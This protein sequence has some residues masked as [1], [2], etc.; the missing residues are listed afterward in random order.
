MSRRHKKG[1]ADER[2][3]SIP[4]RTWEALRLRGVAPA[5]NAAALYV[6]LWSGP[7]SARI[8]GV[9]PSGRAALSEA[10]GWTLD[11]F[12]AAFATLEAADL[13]IAD[14]TARLIYIPEALQQECSRPQS[15]S[16][17][18]LWRRE[19]IALPLC[20][21]KDRIDAD[22][23]ALLGSIGKAFLS[24]YDKGKRT[25]YVPPG[26][27]APQA[28]HQPAPQAAGLLSLSLDPSLDLAPAQ[29]PALAPAQGCVA[30]ATP[31]PVEQQRGVGRAKKGKAAKT[32]EPLPYTVEQLQQALAC[33]C[34]RYTVTPLEQGPTI[35]AQK[36]IRRFTLEQVTR[37]GQWLE[38]GGDAYKRTLDGRNLGDLPT[39]IAHATQ[40]DGK[41]VTSSKTNGTNARTRGSAPVGD[42]SN[43]KPGEEA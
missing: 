17:A 43:I 13:A 37:A 25:E 8:P 12:V 7:M 6:Y 27:A 31:A 33:T 23:R 35:H 21:L 2:Y 24:S 5:P 40:W 20:P 19:W 38:A 32:S 14:W 15:P 11:E 34:S 22:V 3:V 42:F 41:P 18:A 1:P 36:L 30:G 4:V 29:A 10:L 39:W 16:A 9:T 26:Q 28:A